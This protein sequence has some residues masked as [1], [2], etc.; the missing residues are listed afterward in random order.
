M[1]QK[2]LIRGGDPD[3]RYPVPVDDAFQGDFLPA[4][5]L[6][7]AP[8][9]RRRRFKTSPRTP[10]AREQRRRVEVLWI[11]PRAA[12]R[13]RQLP[14]LAELVVEHPMLAHQ[15]ERHLPESF[16]H[17]PSVGLPPDV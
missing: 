15:R 6:E 16:A 12:E 17:L 4:P 8:P 3:E 7:E 10:R 2:R 1:A 14:L 11:S 9:C 13:S 5:E